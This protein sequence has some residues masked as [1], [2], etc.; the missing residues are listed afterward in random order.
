MNL[1]EFRSLYDFTER[2]VLITGG[3]GVLGRTMARTLVECNAKVAILSRDQERAAQSIAEIN[4]DVKSNGRAIYV[5]GDVLETDILQQ[6]KQTL[7]SQFGDV[8][9]LI[10]AAGGNHPSATTTPNLSFF[11]LP[12]DALRHISDLN[13]LG[14]ILP[15]QIFGRSMAERGDGVILNISSTN[16]FR[17][18]TRIPAYS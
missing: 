10:N 11:D 18:L 12:L 2:T 13:L 1:D 3:A 4:R 15:C 17:P 14:T 16:A 9:I 6:A 7:Q 5:H 8:D